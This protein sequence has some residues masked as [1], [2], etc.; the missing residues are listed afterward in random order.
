MKA[1][2]SKAVV[3]TV[4]NRNQANGDLLGE[5][6]LFYKAVEK[7]KGDLAFYRDEIR[8]LKNLIARYFVWLVEEKQ[9]DHVKNL[10]R[11]L[12]A[13]DKSNEL[14]ATSTDEHGIFLA[15]VIGNRGAYNPQDCREMQ[16]DVESDH[17]EFM[18]RFRELKQ[19][20][21]QLAE[22]ILKDPRIAQKLQR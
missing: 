15:T 22:Q 19:N 20:I 7:W 18:H 21:F 10:A 17:V 9:L 13:L 5:L 4:E 2:A 3:G 6:E 11:R 14:I 12:T 1:R 8:F 16:N